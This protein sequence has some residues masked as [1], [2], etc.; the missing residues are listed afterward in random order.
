MKSV[1]D[2][3]EDEVYAFA[4]AAEQLSEHPLGKAIVRCY[5]KKPAA[6]DHFKMDPGEGVSATVDGKLVKAGNLKLLKGITLS[7][8]LAKEAGQI[9]HGRQYRYLRCH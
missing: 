8:T 2:Y 4:A 9:P 1:S 3:T 6:C 5:G 7:K